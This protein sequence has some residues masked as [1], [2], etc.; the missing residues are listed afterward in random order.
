MTKKQIWD[1]VNEPA[2]ARKIIGIFEWWEDEKG[3]EP[4][5]GFFKAM[6]SI[7]PE[8]VRG[9]QRPFGFVAKADD[10]MM[11]F[12]IKATRTSISFCCC[13]L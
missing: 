5:D 11:K 4:F 6:Q 7:V 8:A 3:Y 10:G 12:Y 9:T 1:K 13:E 2:V